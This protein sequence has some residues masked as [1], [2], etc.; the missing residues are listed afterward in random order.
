MFRV[1]RFACRGLCYLA[2][3]DARD[4]SKAVFGSRYRLEVAAEI[5]SG[6]NEVFYNRDLALQLGVAEN[7]VRQELKHF[8]DAGLIARLERV[9]GQQAQYYR[10]VQHP[11]WTSVREI[12]AAVTSSE[13]GSPGV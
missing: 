4:F 5:A 1:S 13:A 9:P 10:R 6:H 11:F 3:M 12:S 2:A 8:L 7:L